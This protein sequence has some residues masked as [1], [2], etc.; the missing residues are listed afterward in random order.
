MRL[1]GGKNEQKKM[2]KGGRCQEKNVVAS[3]ALCCQISSS[4]KAGRSKRTTNDSSTLVSSGGTGKKL[5]LFSDLRIG[6]IPGGIDLPRVRALILESIIK[7]EGGEIVELPGR[8]VK[9]KKKRRRIES[10]SS[11]VSPATILS[12]PPPDVIIRSK[13]Y[14]SSSA[15]AYEFRNR[16]KIAVVSPEWI[17]ESMKHRKRLNLA[18]FAIDSSSSSSAS[19]TTTNTSTDYSKGPNTVKIKRN[20]IENDFASSYLPPTATVTTQAAAAAVAAK[21]S[22][23]ASSRLRQKNV[24]NELWTK[25][26]SFGVGTLAMSVKYPDPAKALSRTAAKKLL[27]KALVEGVQ[28]FD[29]ADTYSPNP[30]QLHYTE[31]LLSEVFA[32]Y[33]MLNASTSS[34]V[35][36]KIPNKS[37]DE[38]SISND[39]KN[40]LSGVVVATKGGFRRINETSTGWREGDMT[41]NAIESCIRGSYR[42]LN[43]HYAFGPI[44]IWMLHHPPSKDRHGIKLAAIFKRVAKLKREG[45]ISH[46]GICNASVSQIKMAS[47]ASGRKM[48]ASEPLSSRRGVLNFCKSEGM[49]FLPHGVFG[50]LKAR[51]GRRCF[52]EDFPEVKE[53]AKIVG[54]NSP[55]A[56]V[57][58]WMRRRWPCI[59]HI[60]GM[61]KIERLEGLT[62]ARR[63]CKSLT[64]DQLQRVDTLCK[65]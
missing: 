44:T 29:T 40:V 7:R 2:E 63:L 37:C 50:G 42:A 19:P 14:K 30:H 60:V 61:R 26:D 31:E 38:F 59:A 3:T 6:I 51:D 47:A 22:S 54:A 21:T 5:M 15:A 24:R 18:T 39:A 36:D 34:T 16:S 65:L 48:R 46:L 4:G 11:S 13:I 56:L 64:E 52:T 62:E 33:S 8:G 32:E 41:P 10:A 43:W 53:I 23:T 20:K 17:S 12:T 35:A 28:L 57:L 58:A 25:F 55:H 49:L 1:K 45:L 9:K 27:R